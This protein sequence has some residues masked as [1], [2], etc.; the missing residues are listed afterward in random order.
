VSKLRY[1]KELSKYP[2]VIC[3]D[4]EKALIAINPKR[5]M[6]VTKDGSRSEPGDLQKMDRSTM[7]PSGNLLWAEEMMRDLINKG[8]I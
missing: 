2:F 4:K 8:I 7:L 6:F 3:S 5:G 1:P